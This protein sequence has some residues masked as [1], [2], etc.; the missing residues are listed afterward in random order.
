[1]KNKIIENWKSKH[2]YHIYILKCVFE[3][4][5]RWNKKKICKRKKK[6]SAR[7]LSLYGDDDDDTALLLYM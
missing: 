1:M 3:R 6:L 5:R 4:I 7:F 2:F